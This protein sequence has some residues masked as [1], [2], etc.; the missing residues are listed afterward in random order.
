M[1]SVK[2]K[3]SNILLSLPYQLDSVDPDLINRFKTNV[4]DIQSGWIGKLFNKVASRRFKQDFRWCFTDQ[5]LGLASR[6]I[7]GIDMNLFKL[8]CF[9][10]VRRFW[11]SRLH[12]ITS[13]VLSNW[14]TRD[15]CMQ[16][17]NPIEFQ[18]LLESVNFFPEII[19]AENLPEMDEFCLIGV[20]DWEELKGSGDITNVKSTKMVVF[21]VASMNGHVLARYV[22]N[23]CIQHVQNNS[24]CYWK[25]SKFAIEWGKSWIEKNF[26]YFEIPN[27]ISFVL[28]KQN[29]LL[30][31]ISTKDHLY[32]FNISQKLYDDCKSSNTCS[33]IKLQIA[34][35]YVLSNALARWGE[36]PLTNS[37]SQ[38]VS[39]NMVFKT[40]TMKSEND[41]FDNEIP[42]FLNI[43]K[44]TVL[45]DPV[46]ENIF[47]IPGMLDDHIRKSQIGSFIEIITNSGESR[48]EFIISEVG[49][50]IGDGDEIN[51]GWM[52]HFG[53]R[54]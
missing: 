48:G 3:I 11:I 7:C 35:R 23:E 2:T 14:D 17:E 5:S 20:T 39:G 49:L 31:V 46:V 1:Q 27:N 30:K 25:I 54:N 12:D 8:D 41:N 28:K 43:S 32:P 26:P 29:R 44:D 13:G 47:L 52:S 16:T 40:S 10:I 15:L 34:L 37:N 42:R 24:V 36:Q 51:E 50:R 38:F 9:P 33:K 18:S 45:F 4:Y 6:S 19:A 53:K 22:S 21:L